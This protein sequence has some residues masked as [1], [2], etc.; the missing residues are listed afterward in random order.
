MKKVM[1]IDDELDILDV[2]ERFL[3]RKGKLKVETYSNAESA[4]KKLRAK[5]YDLILSDIMMPLVSG[6][7]ILKE[8]KS[9]NPN[10]KIILMTAYSSQTKIDTSE[11][12][13]I[14]EYIKKPFENLNE[15]EKK[16]YFLLGI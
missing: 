4:L 5:H 6:I 9:F 10:S 13:G 11:K 2:L 12:F 15:V 1:I 3:T 14:D 7:D 16:I 8:V